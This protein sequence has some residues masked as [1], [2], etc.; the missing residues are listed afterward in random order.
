MPS[1]AVV[2]QF[3]AW[4]RPPYPLVQLGDG[5]WKRWVTAALM[6]RVSTLLRLF[7]ATDLAVTASAFHVIAEVRLKCVVLVSALFR[8]RNTSYS[9]R[10]WCAA[11]VHSAMIF[12]FQTTPCCTSFNRCVITAAFVRV[13]TP[14]PKPIPHVWVL[15]VEEEDRGTSCMIAS[16]RCSSAVIA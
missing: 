11:P 9:C 14:T 10:Y 2:G 7:S 1:A 5:G 16:T 12:F 3:C 13:P 8:R 15:V 4:R 6:S